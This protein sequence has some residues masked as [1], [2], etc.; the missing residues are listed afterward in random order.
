[1]RAKN[2]FDMKVVEC[3]WLAANNISQAY[4]E[5]NKQK[6]EQSTSLLKDFTDP[7]FLKNG[8]VRQLLQDFGM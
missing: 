7:E 4:Y 1:M 3:G 6:I 2:K 8:T 5:E